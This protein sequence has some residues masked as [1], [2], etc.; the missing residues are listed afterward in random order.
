MVESNVHKRNHG[1]DICKWLNS[2]DTVKKWATRLIN[3]QHQVNTND[4]VR[5]LD[6]FPLPIADGIADI[7]EKIPDKQW[8]ITSAS[9][10]YIHNNISHEFFSVKFPRQ[11]GLTA[12]FRVLSILIPE[13]ISSTFS[14]GRYDKSNHIEPHDDRAYAD[15]KIENGA[16]IQCSRSIAVVVYFNKNWTAADGCVP[17]FCLI[18]RMLPPVLFVYYL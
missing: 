13:S 17:L 2:Y 12:L 9:R 15:V 4:I 1:E 5:V 11:D 10:D 16:I 6:F 3:L 8:N 18:S 7:L 14:A